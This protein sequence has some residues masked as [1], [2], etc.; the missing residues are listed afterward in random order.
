[1]LDPVIHRNHRNILNPMFS[2]QSMDR[3]SAGIGDK[4]EQAVGLMERS[5]GTTVDIQNLLRCMDVGLE[6]P[7]SPLK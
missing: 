6:A 3:M 7:P 4:V 5:Q 1:M 2:A